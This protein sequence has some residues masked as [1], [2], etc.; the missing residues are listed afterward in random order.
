MA[1]IVE[2]GDEDE[3]RPGRC[4]EKSG[5]RFGEPV[6]RASKMWQVVLSDLLRLK[7]EMGVEVED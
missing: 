5:V 1:M 7:I 6:W 3:M 2:D 4:T